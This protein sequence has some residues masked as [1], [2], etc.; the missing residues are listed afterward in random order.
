MFIRSQLATFGRQILIEDNA[1]PLQLRTHCYV[2]T[3]ISLIQQH[4][5]ERQQTDT[6]IA[7]SH[8]PHHFPSTPLRTLRKNLKLLKNF[9]PLQR[10]PLHCTT[11]LMTLPGKVN[12]R[13]TIAF[14]MMLLLVPVLL[15]LLLRIKCN[16]SVQF[17]SFKLFCGY[18]M[19]R[20]QSNTASAPPG[21]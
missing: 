15:L 7:R 10:F 3:S 20:K 2:T 14:S 11:L 1:G 19:E 5:I 6:E 13:I 8:L 9:S 21:R 17:G 18:G 12:R 4:P 16:S